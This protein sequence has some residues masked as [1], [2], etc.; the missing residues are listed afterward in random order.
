MWNQPV[1]FFTE[2]EVLERCVLAIKARVSH[3]NFVI[4]ITWPKIK[5][6]SVRDWPF[7]YIYLHGF[8]CVGSR[9]RYVQKISKTVLV[10]NSWNVTKRLSMGFF[11]WPSLPPWASWFLSLESENW[12]EFYRRYRNFQTWI[13]RIEH[14]EWFRIRYRHDSEGL[15]TSYFVRQENTRSLSKFGKCSGTRWAKSIEY[16]CI[17]VIVC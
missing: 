10:G 2:P 17:N 1:G 4:H 6:G 9:W 11:F 14:D 7:F 16:S 3:V 13:Q 15:G 8:K 5:I 12:L